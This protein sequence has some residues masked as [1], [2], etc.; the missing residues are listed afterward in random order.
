[1]TGS[2][3]PGPDGGA[4]HAGEIAVQARAGVRDKAARLTSM[5]RG[6]MPDQ[7]RQF[8]ADSD[9]L[10]LGALDNDGQPWATVLTGEPGFIASPS[11][12][13]LAIGALPLEDDPAR[14]G[15][16][17]GGDV[18][19]LG[20]MPENR[21][22]NRLNGRV[23]AVGTDG[24]ALSVVQ[25]FGNCP[26]Y[27]QTRTREPGTTAGRP[28]AE[29][30]DALTDT[31]RTWIEAADTFFIPS[32]SAP[33]DDDASGVDVSHRGGRPGFVKVEADGA[34]L[35]PDYSGNNLFQTL[36]NITVD[37]R[38]GLLF[39]DFERGDTLQIAGTAEIIWDGPEVE[40]FKGAHRLIRFA[41]GQVVL[42]RSVLAVRFLLNEPSPVLVET[43]TWEEQAK[44]KAVIA[45]RDTYRPFTVA[46]IHDES[47][48]IRSFYLVPADGG[49]V[50][51]HQP[52]QYLPIRLTVPGHE[53]PVLRTYT[54]SDAHQ[55]QGLRITVKRE[56]EGVASRF[57]HDTV[58]VGDTIEAMAPRG[59]FVLNAASGRPV[60]LLSAGVAITP[61]IAM[62]NHLVREGVKSGEFRNVVFVHGARDGSEL[63][64][65][66]HLRT[67]GANAPGVHLHVRF[68]K[69]RADDVP[70]EDYASAGRVDLDLLQRLLPFG[71]YDFYL[72]GPGAFVADLHA[73]LKG[74]NVA[75]DRIHYEFFGPSSLPTAEGKVDAEPADVTFEDSDITAAWTPE[76]GSLLDLAETSGVTVDSSC[77]SGRC[78]SCAVRLVKGA[79]GYATTPEATAPDGHVL[80]CQAHPVGDVVLGA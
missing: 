49:G 68:S 36:G 12:T 34:I 62:L 50:V 26:Q 29:I 31:H 11:A 17:A 23:D 70:G 22:R 79:V 55:E 37:P 74:L 45:A 16:V 73:G 52:G 64:F 78:G 28:A 6:A 24:F 53:K 5:I 80:A 44:T 30:T 77:R 71:D 66:D 9:L 41:P 61:M 19:L 32:R 65:G 76:S 59:D 57:L 75:D 3:T 10:F 48:T 13:L 33:G 25:S 27:I 38:A 4:F 14:A 39:V 56:A 51:A 54:V 1:M 67:L 42:R 46:G 72:C 18:G 69:P 20:L 35:F 58:R 40:A 8:F 21:R 43:G 60:V 47:A 63:A 2:P 15:I 7:H